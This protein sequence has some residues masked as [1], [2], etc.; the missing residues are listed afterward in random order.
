MTDSNETM[1]RAQVLSK[2]TA[3][4][5]AAL[6]EK[7]TDEW[8]AAMQAAAKELGEEWSPRLT[9]EQRAKAEYDALVAKYPHLAQQS[10]P[11]YVQG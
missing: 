5:N 1:T 4:A 2:A 8:N 3:A 9:E 10:E 7:Y 11:N 6:K